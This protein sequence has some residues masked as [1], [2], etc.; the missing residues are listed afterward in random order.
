MVAYQDDFATLDPA[1]GY[2]WS[3]WPAIKNVFDGLLDYDAGTTLEPRLADGMPQ[4][5]SDAKVYTFKLRQGVKFQNGRELTADDV[6]YSMTRVVDPKT[7][8]PGAGFYMGIQGAREFADGKAKS[9]QGIEAPDKYTVKFT[10]AEPDVTFLNKLA[11][12]FAYVVPKEEVA[13]WGEQFGHHPVGTGPFLFKEWQPGQRIVF[14]RNPNYFFGGLPYLDRVTIEVGVA[15]EV[16]ILRLEK[17]EID[18][19][20]DPIPAAEYARIKADPA[21]QK[22]LV[23]S[24]QVSTIYIAINTRVKPFDNVKVR[25]ALNM[26]IDKA[27][28]VKLLNGRGTTANQILPPLMPGYDQAYKGYEYSPDKAKSLLAEAGFP[29]GFETTIA[30]ISTD[31][32][33]KLCESFQQDLSKIG[34]KLNIQSLA[35]STVIENAGTEGKV[36]LVWTGGLGWI[37]DYPDPDDF[38]APLFACG[39]AV[40]GGWNW[41]WYCNA[42]LDKQ[43]AKLLGSIDKGARVTGYQALFRKL[44]DD[45]VAVPVYHGQY[46]IARSEKLHG[47]QGDF[48]H[49][50]HTLRYERLWKQ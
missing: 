35:S 2:D 24:P 42:D 31:P 30:C 23:Q 41:S 37:Q 11:L 20:G 1:I 17:G 32:Q 26:A 28:V 16:A 7:K 46:D 33:P 3:N 6:V 50:E 13:K 43:A 47:N 29:Q 45:A 40:Q 38:Y 8:S 15:P 36:P 39:S 48:G 49:P 19:M 25:Q 4:V 34:I 21:A 27:R 10:L 18:V 14:D 5:S 44:M 22:R 12:N 9:V